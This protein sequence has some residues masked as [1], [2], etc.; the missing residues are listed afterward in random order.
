MLII[1]EKYIRSG[2]RIGYKMLECQSCE[3]L[4]HTLHHDT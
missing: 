1:F 4:N 2:P 3:I